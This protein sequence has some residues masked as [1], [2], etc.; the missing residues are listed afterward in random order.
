MAVY[1]LPMW[2][3]TRA[4]PLVT[5]RVVHALTHG[6]HS[7]LRGTSGLGL[8]RALGC[9]SRK[10]GYLSRRARKLCQAGERLVGA[11]GRWSLPVPVPSL[12]T[13]EQGH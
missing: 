1:A 10:P 9:R 8:G 12:R 11:A 6:G 4:G 2:V 13:G 5:W 3:R 7:R